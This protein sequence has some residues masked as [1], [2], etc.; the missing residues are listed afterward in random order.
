LE[1]LLELKQSRQKTNQEEDQEDEH[2]REIVLLNIE[3]AVRKSIEELEMIHQVMNHPFQPRSPND[4]IYYY[5][6]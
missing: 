6:Y 4:T 5:Y 2:E 1:Q 3:M